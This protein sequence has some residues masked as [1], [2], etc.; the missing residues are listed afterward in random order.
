MST[1]KAMD[2]F[3]DQW[4]MSHIS[5]KLPKFTSYDVDIWIKYYSND[6]ELVLTYSCLKSNWRLFKYSKWLSP[7]ETPN[8]ILSRLQKRRQT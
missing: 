8:I 3:L 7:K 5:V 1:P 6:D 2:T 4:Y